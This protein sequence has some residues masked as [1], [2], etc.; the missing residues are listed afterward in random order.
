MVSHV[1]KYMG[2]VLASKVQSGEQSSS[3]QSGVVGMR[4]SSVRYMVGVLSYFATEMLTCAWDLVESEGR[5]VIE[6]SDVRTTI[7]EDEELRYMNVA[8]CLE[9]GFTGEGRL[10]EGSGRGTSKSSSS[11]SKS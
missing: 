6:I 5:R 2:H 7:L 3:E 9:V 10:T 8:A 11:E 4:T 1:K